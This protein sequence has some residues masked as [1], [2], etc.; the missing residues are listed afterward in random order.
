MLYELIA[1]VQVKGPS[2]QVNCGSVSILNTTNSTLIVSGASD[3]WL[4]W[5]GGTDY[6][7][8]AGDTAHNYS[9]KGDDPHQQLLKL[10]NIASPSLTEALPFAQIY[11][12]ARTEHVADVQSILG[13]FSLTLPFPKNAWENQQ[14][15]L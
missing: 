15:N 7:I 13:A 9:F 10:I 6:N 1:R 5:V 11:T 14:M 12:I 3:V 8:T 2:A 4:R